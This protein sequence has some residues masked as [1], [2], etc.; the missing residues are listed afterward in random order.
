MFYVRLSRH[1]RMKWMVN[2]RGNIDDD[3]TYLSFCSL[4]EE[5]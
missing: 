5:H 4:E 1:T 3:G 2:E